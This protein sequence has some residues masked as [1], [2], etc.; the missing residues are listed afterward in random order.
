MLH[1]PSLCMYQCRQPSCVLQGAKGAGFHPL[2]QA[3]EGKRSFGGMADPLVM[4]AVGRGN[5][6]CF[7]DISIGGESGVE[8]CGGDEHSRAPP[9]VQHLHSSKCRAV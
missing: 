2:G 8:G 1:R 9:K 4:E 3:R 5:P 6:V 7:M